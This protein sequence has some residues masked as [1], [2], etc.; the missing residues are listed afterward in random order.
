MYINRLQELCEKENITFT[1]LGKTINLDRSTIGKYVNGYLPI[2]LKHLNSICNFFDISLDYILNLTDIKQYKNY[3]KEINQKLFSERL[4]E[5]RKEKNIT[6]NKL[7]NII[8]CSHSAISEYEKGK[9]M[10]TISHLNTICKKYH[11]SADYLLGKI[12]N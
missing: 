6:Q 9:R 4:K 3:K 8:N 1:E 12:E 7:A 2:P 5:F 11:I 10:I